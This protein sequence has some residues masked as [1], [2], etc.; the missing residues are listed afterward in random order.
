MK[1]KKITVSIFQILIFV[2]IVCIISIIAIVVVMNQ[3]D[4]LYNYNLWIEG[5]AVEVNSQEHSI[6]TIIIS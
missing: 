2:L 3:T 6:S 4:K 5:E 1:T